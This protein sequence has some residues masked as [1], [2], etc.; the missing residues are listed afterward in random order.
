MINCV[1]AGT[2]PPVLMLHGFPQ[3]Q[4]MWARVAPIV[5]EQFTVVCADLRGYGDSSKPRCSSDYSNYSFR[6]MA[7]DQ[8][9]L[10]NAFGFD[11]F[12]LV[13][14]DRG[15]R[16]GHRMAQGVAFMNE[17]SAT[18][19]SSACCSRSAEVDGRLFVGCARRIR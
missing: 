14:H 13:G 9:G 19:K 12:H 10:I 2:G 16:T 17:A 1:V 7:A 8:V 5:A 11:R 3:N 15:G 4:S 6:T 18:L